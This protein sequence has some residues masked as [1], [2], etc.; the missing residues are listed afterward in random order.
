ME[1]KKEIFADELAQIHFIGDMVRLD[2]MTLQPSSEE[3]TPQTRS[4]FRIIMSLQGFLAACGSMQQ[5]IN[6]LLE[7][8]VLQKKE[9]VEDQPPSKSSRKRKK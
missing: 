9:P 3:N 2:F 7:S 1:E 6:R 8:G 5:L 4:E